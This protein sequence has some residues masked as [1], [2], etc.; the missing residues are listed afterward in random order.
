MSVY[1]DLLFYDSNAAILIFWQILSGMA[2][3][4]ASVF[5]AAFFH[6]KRISSIFVVICFCCLG[7]G[8][9]I[10][11]NR[12]AN[13]VNVGVLSALFPAMNYIFILVQVNGAHT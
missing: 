12:A 11:I 13:T 6:R 2:F 3:V 8:A 10:L 4:A 7:G 1:F 9:A 5:G